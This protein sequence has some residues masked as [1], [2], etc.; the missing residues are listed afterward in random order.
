[1]APLTDTAKGLIVGIMTIPWQVQGYLLAISPFVYVAWKERAQRDR[2]TP[3]DSRRVVRGTPLALGVAMVLCALWLVSL[4]DSAATM[5]AI[6]L[7]GMGVAF[8]HEARRPVAVPRTKRPK[9]AS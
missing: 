5:T 2:W 6:V 1:M 9:F 3:F 7:G 8:I 4:R